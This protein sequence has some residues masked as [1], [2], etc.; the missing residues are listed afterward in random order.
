VT[1]EGKYCEN[2]LTGFTST[3]KWSWKWNQA[4]NKMKKIG[5]GT[6]KIVAELS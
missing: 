1:F 6:S 5:T 2:E 3:L 4:R